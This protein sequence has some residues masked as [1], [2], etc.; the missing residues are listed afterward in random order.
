M[1][2]TLK[3][4]DIFILDRCVCSQQLMI[5]SLDFYFVVIYVTSNHVAGLRVSIEMD[6]VSRE[7]SC[8]KGENKKRK[9]KQKYTET[10]AERRQIRNKGYIVFSIDK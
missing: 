5:S 4:I 9:E 8:R 7:L 6:L 1:A 10:A 3:H 2:T